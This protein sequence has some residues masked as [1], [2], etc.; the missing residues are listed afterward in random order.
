[1]P[2]IGGRGAMS[3]ALAMEARTTIAKYNDLRIDVG[4][5][6]MLR[7]AT[8]YSSQF[9]IDCTNW[10]SPAPRLGLVMS[11][12]LAPQAA[13]RFCAPDRASGHCNLVMS[14]TWKDSQTRNMEQLSSLSWGGATGTRNLL[15]RSAKL[16]IAYSTSHCYSN[17]PTTSVAIAQI[18]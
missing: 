7:G 3:W 1:M 17:C 10:L 8:N 18:Y 4:R 9:T 5:E 15:Q 6:P 16:R 14:L 12:R 11:Y 2:V 13:R